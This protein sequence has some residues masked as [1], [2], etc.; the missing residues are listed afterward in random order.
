MIRF[1]DVVTKITRVTK[2]T[3]VFVVFVVFVSFVK[4]AV[5]PAPDLL[6]SCLSGPVICTTS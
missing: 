5:G 1:H 2:I 6:T 3:K 4:R